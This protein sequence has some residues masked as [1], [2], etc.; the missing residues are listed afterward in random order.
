MKVTI[1]DTLAPCH[2]SLCGVRSS[3]SG[4][5]YNNGSGNHLPGPIS[6][7]CTPRGPVL[8][9]TLIVDRRRTTDLPNRIAQQMLTRCQQPSSGIKSLPNHIINVT[10]LDRHERL[11][12][13]LFIHR[14]EVDKKEIQDREVGRFDD[15]PTG[16]MELQ[17]CKAKCGKNSQNKN[18]ESWRRLWKSCCRRV[19]EISI[20]I[21][22]S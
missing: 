8:K 1:C 6:E 19:K 11:D 22:P 17:L 14:P 4:R 3:N 13:S 16:R 21:K 2:R 12:K 10:H 9:A 7:E 15:R 18:C 5:L 20:S